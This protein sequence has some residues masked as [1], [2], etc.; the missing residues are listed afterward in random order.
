MSQGESDEELRARVR[1]SLFNYGMKHIACNYVEFTETVFSNS[2]HGLTEVPTADYN[3]PHIPTNPLNIINVEEV[4]PYEEKL[5]SSEEAAAYIETSLGTLKGKPKS[6]RVYYDDE[7]VDAFRPLSEPFE[8]LLP[9]KCIRAAPCSGAPALQLPKFWFYQDSIKVPGIG[10][11]SIEPFEEPNDGVLDVM[12]TASED[13]DRSMVRSLSQEASL[14]PRPILGHK[15]AYPDMSCLSLTSPL[16]LRPDPR[17]TPILARNPPDFR[18]AL[19]IEPNIPNP[20]SHLPLIITSMTRAPENEEARIYKEHTVI[21]EWRNF[22]T[23]S[24]SHS[25]LPTSSRGDEEIDQLF[26]ISSPNTELQSIELLE[27]PRI[28]AAILQ[29]RQWSSGPEIHTPIGAKKKLGANKSGMPPRNSPG[30][31]SLGLD[32]EQDMED[33]S[34]LW[35]VDGSGRYLGCDNSYPVVKNSR[36]VAGYQLESDNMGMKQ[37]ATPKSNRQPELAQHALGILK[38]AQLRAKQIQPTAEIQDAPLLIPTPPLEGIQNLHVP[39]ES[40][41]DCNTLRLP[42]QEAPQVT[43]THIYM[44]SL[45]ALQKQALVRA[46]RSRECGVDLA[47]REYLDGMDFILDPHTGVL[48]VSLFLLPSQCAGLVACIKAQSWRFSRILVL[49]E[50]YPTAHSYREP[51]QSG[52]VTPSAYTPPIMKA[53]SKFRRDLDI[54]EACGEKRGGT[55]NYAFAN[56]VREAAA[57]V[58]YYGELAEGASSASMLWDMRE[59]LEEKNEAEDELVEV[60]AMNRFSAAVVLARVSAEE[61]MGMSPEARVDMF[62]PLIGHDVVDTFNSKTDPSGSDMLIADDA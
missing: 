49:C 60:N 47:E 11:I 56:N 48:L 39:P 17:L 55:V 58:R 22:N 44:A 42:S 12:R 62:G 31:D 61:L 10:E 2:L 53:L 28:D 6:D 16:P 38:F 43:S 4:P 35:L 20:M 23:P 33:D 54:A 52:G 37:T 25:S 59:W 21:D 15:N 50:A 3:S 7:Y 24:P 9:L 45:Q 36:P 30:D 40:I 26:E 32:F 19:D 51:R 13:G 27:A 46:L 41:L 14:L 18:Q 29:S 34:L 8:P 5:Q 57:L 1:A